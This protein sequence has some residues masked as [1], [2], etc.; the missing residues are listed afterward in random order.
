LGLIVP[1]IKIS[2]NLQL[3]AHTYVIRIRGAQVA[4]GKVY[5]SQFLALSDGDARG[6]LVGREATDPIGG[7]PGVWISANQRPRAEALNHTVVDAGTVLMTHLAETI[8]RHGADLLTREQVAEILDALGRRCPTLVGDVRAKFDVGRVQAVLQNLLRERAAIR[9]MVTILEAMAANES[10]AADVDL[11]TERVRSA[12]RR[13][14]SQQH[15]G[16]DGKLRCVSLAP[17]VED[18]LCGQ[19]VSDGA[20]GEIGRK[21]ARALGQSLSRLR[22]LGHDPVVLCGPAVRRKLRG[23]LAAEQPE[24]AVLATSEIDA[25]EVEPLERVGVEP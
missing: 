3:G 22:K 17:E 9:D 11:L 5:P 13:T 23:L 25:V 21:A 4:S 18:A 1:P 24:A 14:L 12:L 19:F 2:D 15:C 7:L 16:R 8:H 20:E 10:L 6:E